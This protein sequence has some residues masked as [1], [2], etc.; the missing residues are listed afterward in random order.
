MFLNVRLFI[1]LPWLA[2]LALL[3]A[4]ASGSA[5]A[6]EQQMALIGNFQVAGGQLKDCRLGY[7]TYGT[8]A[9]DQSNVVLFPTWAG[10]RTVDLEKWIGPG[11]LVDSSKW[12]VVAVDALGNGVSCSPSN[13]R[14]TPARAFPGY[15]IR[16]MVRA[17]HKM[18]TLDL[19]IDHL[20]GIVGIGMGGMQGLQWAVT[21]QDFA[22]RLVLIG[23]SAQPTDQ[24]RKR[25]DDQLRAME[26]GGQPAIG[27]L[28]GYRQLQAIRAF[29]LVGSGDMATL[30]L[31]IKARMLVIAS[32]RDSWVEPA[33]V[34]LLAAQ[35]RKARYLLIDS[36]CADQAVGCDEREAVAAVAEFLGRP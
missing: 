7:R 4:D 36:L 8:L 17:Q 19:G 15:S 13:S 14:S 26:A 1:W 2:A 31:K 5:V 3:L 30:A 12:Y 22:D 27:T 16:D 34:R 25:W 20:H 33:S 6:A 21:Y 18:L 35:A 24:D 11:L 32:I 9:P 10:A 29:D 23:T 28:D